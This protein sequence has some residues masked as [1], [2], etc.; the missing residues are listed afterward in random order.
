L[1]IHDV[2]GPVNV[3]SR[4]D[5]VSQTVNNAPSIE[6][7]SREELSKLFQE[8]RDVL[9]PVAKA[10]PQDGER[11]IQSA[12]MVVNE[13]TKEKPSKSFLDITLAGLTEAAKAV[14]AIAP[15][16]LTVATKIASFVA[17]LV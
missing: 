10:K 1:E 4:L 13:V 6:K 5:R 17:T 2:V 11:V 7:K 16:V 8:L 3:K 12:E 15:S 9:E 14:E